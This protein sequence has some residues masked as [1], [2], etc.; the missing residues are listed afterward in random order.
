MVTSE[1]WKHVTTFSSIVT[2]MQNAYVHREEKSRDQ[3]SDQCKVKILQ[4]FFHT[5]ILLCFYTFRKFR[6]SE[7]ILFCVWNCFSEDHPPLLSCCTHWHLLEGAAA[8]AKAWRDE[9]F[10]QVESRIAWSHFASAFGICLPQCLDCSVKCTTQ[11]VTHTVTHSRLFRSDGGSAKLSAFVSYFSLG[12]WKLF[13]WIPFP[14]NSNYCATA[15]KLG[16]TLQRRIC[17]HNSRRRGV[18]TKCRPRC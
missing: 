6:E 17:Q 14:R 9:K 15:S 4:L 10:Q 12:R 7:C 5:N 1:V 16:A 11:W 18:I 2:S 13:F 3:R 8:G